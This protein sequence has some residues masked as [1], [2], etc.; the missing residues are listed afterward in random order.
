VCRAGPSNDSHRVLLLCNNE[1]AYPGGWYKAMNL[2]WWWPFPS[3]SARVWHRERLD[4]GKTGYVDRRDLLIDNAK[5][6]LY[7]PPKEQPKLVPV[8]WDETSAEAAAATREIEALT[9]RLN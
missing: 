8:S 9:R 7:G 4:G 5:E 3:W 6:Q 2:F 1:V